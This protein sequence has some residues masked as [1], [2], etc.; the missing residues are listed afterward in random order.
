MLLLPHLPPWS[1]VPQVQGFIDASVLTAVMA[2][3]I[4]LLVVKPLTRLLESRGELLHALFRVQEQERS[5]IARDLHDEIGQQ[6]TA[7]LIGL[8]TLEAAQDLSSVRKIAQHLR[9]VGGTAHEEVRRLARGLRPGVLEDL[10]LVAAVERLC[11]D[12]EQAHGLAVQLE[13]PATIGK[14]TLPI[15][16]SL[17]RILQ[18]SLTN[19]VRHAQA[20]TVNVSLTIVDEIVRLSIVDDGCG[21]E[22]DPHESSAAVPLSLG[23][24][25]IRERAEMLHGDCVIRS[26]DGGGTLIEVRIPSRK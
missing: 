19:V 12:F 10:G 23:L 3:V 6:L 13:T 2:P 25:S 5:R 1:K 11:E 7:L 8:G 18:E 14:L 15:E 22:S 21:L 24:K 4:W 9:K 16:V 26:A 17:Y 20:R